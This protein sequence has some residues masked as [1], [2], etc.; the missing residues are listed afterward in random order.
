MSENSSEQRAADLLQDVIEDAYLDQLEAELDQEH[1]VDSEV[2]LEDLTTGRLSPQDLSAFRR[3]LAGCL[4][5]NEVIS[6][7]QDRCPMPWLSEDEPAV[8]EQPVP[9][10]AVVPVQ[11]TGSALQRAR[12]QF[13]SPKPARTSSRGP[14]VSKQAV[15]VAAAAAVLLLALLPGIRRF[16]PPTGFQSAGLESAFTT[17]ATFADY[18]LSSLVNA[19]DLTPADTDEQRTQQLREQLQANPRDP[20]AMLNL[21]A[22]LLQTRQ[23]EESREL[24]ES[25]LQQRPEDPEVLNALGLVQTA[26]GESRSAEE[27]FRRAMGGRRFFGPAVLNLADLLVAQGRQDDAKQVLTQALTSSLSSADREQLERR[28]QRLSGEQS[29]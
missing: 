16:F 22:R 9:A 28:I 13:A 27:T 15:V 2:F 4:F 8:A 1:P 21:A 25:V 14:W 20:A 24:I 17:A 12:E 10:P 7:L 3:H 6:A 11:A 5:C 26:G 29:P 18:G 19:R 23:L